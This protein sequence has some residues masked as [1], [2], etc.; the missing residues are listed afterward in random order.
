[1]GFLTDPVGWFWQTVAAAIRN[2]AGDIGSVVGNFL[3]ATTDVLDGG[4]AF[5][6]GTVIAHFQP[7]VVAVADAA[8]AAVIVW[9]AYHVM[10]SHGLR[11]LYTVR[12]LLP[13]VLLAVVLVNLSLPLVQ[14]AIDANNVLCAGVLGLGVAFDPGSLLASRDFGSGPGLS[15]AVLAALFAG[16]GVLGVAY[17][18]RYSLLIVLTI[19]APLAAILSVLPDTQAY[20]RKWSSLF[21]STLLMQP[22]QLLVLQVGLQ[23]DLG[24]AA[25]NPVRHVFALATLI[26]AFK[27]PG[28][29]S[30]T[31][32][33]GTHAISAAKHLAHVVVHAAEHAV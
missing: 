12:I 30:A 26:L 21:V 28:A 7:A 24:A 25:W 32:T 13:R 3:F 20:A 29:L 5:T 19:T 31:S 1:M 23:L 27:V 9:G 22:L 11:S 8:L 16:Y 14:A 33:A 2:G 4:R 18:L 17:A 15:L 6:E 10:F